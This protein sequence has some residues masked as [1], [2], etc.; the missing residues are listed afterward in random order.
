MTNKTTYLLPIWIDL[1]FG[2]PE[3]IMETLNNELSEFFEEQCDQIGKKCP[4][5]VKWSIC[6]H[7]KLVAEGAQK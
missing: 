1:E 7:I 5:E 3:L 2:K 4:V 6:K